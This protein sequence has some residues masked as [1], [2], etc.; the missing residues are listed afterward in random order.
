[1]NKN[2][3]LQNRGTKF[4]VYCKEECGFSTREF[5]KILLKLW[6]SIVLNGTGI[7]YKI[8]LSPWGVFINICESD[9]FLWELTNICGCTNWCHEEMCEWKICIMCVKCC[10]IKNVQKLC[11]WQPLILPYTHHLNTASISLKNSI[12]HK[13]L[14]QFVIH[15][16]LHE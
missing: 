13:L 11:P 9:N 6:S 14:T 12:C 4:G 8:T 16:S 1:M 3:F 10:A 7:Q 2:I 5:L 15:C